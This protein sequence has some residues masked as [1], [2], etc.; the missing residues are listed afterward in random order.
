MNGL[1]DATD[2]QRAAPTARL[3]HL[4]V[5]HGMAAFDKQVYLQAMHDKQ[6][7]ELRLDTGTLTY[8]GAHGVLQPYRVQPIGTHS[9]TER[10]FRWAWANPG[11]FPDAALLA[12]A[13]QLRAFGEAQQLPQLTTPEVPALDVRNADVFALIASGICRAGCYFR[14]VY[15]DGALYLLIRDPS[16]KRPVQRPL[17]RI[18]RIVPLFLRVHPLPDAQTALAHY[19]QFYRLT[20]HSVTTPDGGTHMTVQ[21]RPG[22]DA[23]RMELQPLQIEFDARRRLTQISFDAEL[24]R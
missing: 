2:A 10:T 4:F 1:S 15:P 24:R 17:A 21:P 22:Q 11:T 13:Q 9:A 14:A 5:Q 16:F 7:W 3:L 20:P 6:H 12:S 23:V 18:A 8:T 19:L